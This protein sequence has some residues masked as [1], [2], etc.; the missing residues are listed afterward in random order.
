[1]ANTK[2]T[3]PKGTALY[4][5]LRKPEYYEGAEV[6][7]TIQMRFSKE[8]T[9][10]LIEALENE[11]DAAKGSSDFKGK[12]WTNARIGTKEDKN[13]DIVFKFKTKT[14]YKTK[15]GDIVQ[16][17]VPIFDA[18]GK[19][20]KGDIGTGSIC[21]VRFTTN[22]YHKSATN[23]GLTLYLDAVQVIDFK[24]PGGASAE[25]FGFDVEDGFSVDDINNVP[26]EADNKFENEEF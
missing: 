7:Y 5:H 14:S 21:K 23:C 1:M 20:I 11:L 24:E 9:D 4:P 16:R 10:K 19:P 2:I 22:P 18:K 15:A 26:D 8:D 3:T 6:G 17:T 12:K 13:G 25:S